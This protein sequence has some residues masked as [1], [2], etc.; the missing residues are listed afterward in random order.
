ME[1][2][3]TSLRASPWRR[4]WDTYV[5]LFYLWLPD[6]WTSLCHTATMMC[7]L[8]R[9]PK[10]CEWVE[11]GPLDHRSKPPNHEPNNYFSVYVNWLRSFIIVRGSWLTETF[12]HWAAFCLMSC[13]IKQW[14]TLFHN[15]SQQ[16]HSLLVWGVFEALFI[17]DQPETKQ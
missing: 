10:V 8:N 7:Y 13:Q 9:G 11:G 12:V 15:N 5:F 16:W 14:L 6:W 4:L 1:L 3:G 17:Y 2:Y